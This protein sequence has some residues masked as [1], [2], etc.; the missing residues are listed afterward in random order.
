MKYTYLLVNLVSVAVPFAFSFES[1][2]QFYKKWKALFPSLLIP[3]ILFLIWDSYFTSIGV[4]GF[5]EKYLTGIQVYNLPLEEILFFICI[6][7][8]CVF[9]YE[10]LNYFVKQDV[11]GKYARYG[12]T[13]V[14]YMLV[15]VSFKYSDKAYTVSTSVLTTLFLLLHLVVLK[16][17]YWS[18]LVFAYLVILV[19]FFM[20]NGILTGTGLD[21]PIVWYNDEENLGVRMLTIPAEDAIYGFL[22]IASNITL[23][24]HFK[25]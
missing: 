23:F 19:P 13:I 17:A 7:Y 12:T 9:T 18:K 3:G 8:C 25:R 6:P 16:K 11:L 15:A 2:I 10:V 5:N 4:W 24:E 21:E 22:L 14:A 20:V 1:K